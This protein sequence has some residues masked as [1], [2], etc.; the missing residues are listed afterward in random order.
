ME[1]IHFDILELIPQRKPFLFVDELIDFEQDSSL[2][3]FRVPED[4][5][6][7]RNGRLSE[8]GLLENIA[9]SCA[10]RIGYINKINNKT[11]L[12]G[13]IGSVKDF[14]V[15]FL[16]EVGSVLTTRIEVLNEV[17]GITLV[18]ARSECASGTA[19]TCQMKISLIGM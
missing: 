2:T 10:A 17:F 16:P 4:G 14:K 19:A 15:E 12:Q 13:V 7:V 1:T 8:A 9:Q 5:I 3:T 6:L 18:N 11:I